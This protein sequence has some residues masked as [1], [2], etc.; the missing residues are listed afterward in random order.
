LNN[1]V[2][3]SPKA[4]PGSLFNQN[5]WN[6]SATEEQWKINTAGTNEWKK[7]S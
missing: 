6:S 7:N 5:D 1:S 3:P 4:D 2:S